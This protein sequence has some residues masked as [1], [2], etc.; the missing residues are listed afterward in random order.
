MSKV[1]EIKV[2]ETEEDRNHG[3]CAELEHIGLK[4]SI[5]YCL[6]LIDDNE[7]V[8]LIDSKE[9]VL[10]NFSWEQR[11]GIKRKEF[12]YYTEESK[13]LLHL[14]NEDKDRELQEPINLYS[15][16]CKVRY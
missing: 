12:I 5:E 4:D 8:E 10:L 1:Y 13:E 2:W 3:L 16:D 11:G 14:L 6:L 9:N 7:C 15:S